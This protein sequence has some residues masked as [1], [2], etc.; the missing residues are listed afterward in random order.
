[1]NKSM[2]HL[3]GGLQRPNSNKYHSFG[4]C[5]ACSCVLP[6]LQYSALRGGEKGVVMKRFTT[7]GTNDQEGLGLIPAR[8][9]TEEEAPPLGLS[10][11]GGGVAGARTYSR[12][13]ALRLLGGSLVG[14]SLLSL[15]L[16]DPVKAVLPFGIRG[17]SGYTIPQLRYVRNGNWYD[18]T[19]QWKCVFQPSVEN[20]TFATAWRLMESDS[21]L[22]ADDI[23]NATV[24]PHQHS[25]TSPAKTFIPSQFNP[26]NPQ[27]ISF[28]AT[29]GWHVD[30]LDTEIGNEELYA[31]V[32]LRDLTANVGPIGVDSNELNLSP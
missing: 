27:E 11:E 9:N 7:E 12:R 8:R 22:G 5:A 3:A 4:G 17:P 2:M 13:Q 28:R 32:L 16:A 25:A 10:F 6:S 14:V 15:G 1:V 30:D 24:S 21:P 26:S 19:L 31:T 20:H 29:N 23:V 18:L